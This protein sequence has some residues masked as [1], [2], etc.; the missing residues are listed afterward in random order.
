M[1]LTAPSSARACSVAIWRE[2]AMLRWNMA[3]ACCA[4]CVAATW[5]A[6]LWRTLCSAA[7][8]CRAAAR[9]SMAC[10]QHDNGYTPIACESETDVPCF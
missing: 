10:L 8:C 5:R 9:L 4:R 7:A 6:S 3:A 2:T 1:A